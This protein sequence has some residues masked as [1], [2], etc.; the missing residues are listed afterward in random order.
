MMRNTKWIPTALIVLSAMVCQAQT[1]FEGVVKYHTTNTAV[2]EVA[3]VTWYSKNG[4][5]RFDFQSK[6]G[7]QQLSYSM[8]MDNQ[9][10]EALLTMGGVSQ[11]VSGITADK[12]IAGASFTRKTNATENGY[13]CEML[14]FKSGEYELV[15]WM[16]NE[17]PIS[18]KQL[19]YLVK[20]NMPKME[21]LSSGFPVKM[22]IRD[23]TGAIVQS[24]D[25]VEVSRTKVE[26]ALFERK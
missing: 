23:A 19:P 10:K 13:A 16:T 25:V 12:I 7:D 2:K 3:E 20:N 14:M 21:G 17:V 15:Y 22:E 8:L 4:K 26:D 1:A 9:E 24:Q 6:A 18:Y 11:Y 5:N